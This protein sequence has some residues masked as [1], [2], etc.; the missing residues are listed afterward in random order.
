VKI[1]E[2]PISLVLTRIRAGYD[3]ILNISN[4]LYWYNAIVSIFAAKISC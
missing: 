4:Y 3:R 1:S 2:R